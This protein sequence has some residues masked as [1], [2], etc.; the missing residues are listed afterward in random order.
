MTV[1]PQ[2]ILRSSSSN[3]TGGI[4]HRVPRQH[5]DHWSVRVLA[6][7]R[8]C[9]LHSQAATRVAQRRIGAFL[10]KR[11]HHPGIGMLGRAM[12]RIGGLEELF[13]ASVN[14][15]NK[16][17]ALQEL[18]YGLLPVRCLVHCRGRHVGPRRRYGRGRR[19]RRGGSRPL[20]GCGRIDAG[21]CG[22][23][24]LVRHFRIAREGHRPACILGSPERL[25]LLHALLT[26]QQGAL[27]ASSLVLLEN[28][29]L[30]PALR[31][32]D[33]LLLPQRLELST[34][35]GGA[36]RALHQSGSPGPGRR[37]P[38]LLLQTPERRN[39]IAALPPGALVARSPV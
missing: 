2:S 12:Q 10:Q 3:S 33:I 37:T 27:D 18:G 35:L 20:A 25:E 39:L 6:V 34:A 8:P 14:S 32:D 1:E 26:P 5:P 11:L 31:P 29:A 15:A 19:G 38:D 30:H 28:F 9:D 13:L 16:P 24:V 7:E 22:D 4:K 17:M 36:L 21:P 23:G